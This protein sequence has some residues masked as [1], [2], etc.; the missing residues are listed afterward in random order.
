MENTLYFLPTGDAMDNA[1]FAA[2]CA[3]VSAVRR[4]KIAAQRRYG[5]AQNALLAAVAVRLL[6]AEALGAENGELQFTCTATG[7]PYLAGGANFH[8]GI[9]HTDGAVALAVSNAAVGVDIE[10]IR[11]APRGVAAR[12]FTP[13]EQTFCAASDAR[14]FEVWTRKEALAKRVGTPLAEALG[15]CNTLAGSAAELARG[16]HTDGFVLAVASPAADTFSLS[17][18]APAELTCRALARLLPID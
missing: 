12:F 5:D 4:A 1:D 6:A 3:R 2:L 8:F 15:A 10:R 16:F 17:K 14:F 18:L 7:K 9:A 13:E 11:T